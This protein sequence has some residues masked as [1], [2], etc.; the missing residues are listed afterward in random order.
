MPGSVWVALC[1]CAPHVEGEKPLINCLIRAAH[2]NIMEPKGKNLHPACPL[3]HALEA[4]VK[5]SL[6]ANTNRD[7]KQFLTQGFKLHAELLN[8]KPRSFAIL[9]LALFQQFCKDSGL[10]NVGLR[11]KVGREATSGGKMWRRPFLTAG[12]LK[13][14]P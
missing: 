2:I 10:A 13:R 11:G 7:A 4:T 1:M 3:R 8:S 14:A 9:L 12:S 6:K 5:D